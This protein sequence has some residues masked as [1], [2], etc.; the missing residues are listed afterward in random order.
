MA[1]WTESNQTDQI[2]GPFLDL[3][4]GQG[5]VHHQGLGNGLTNADARIQGAI[6]ILKHGLHTLAVHFELFAFQ[7]LN[8]VTL[9]H[10]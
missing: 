5:F 1:R 2:A 7:S 4:F 6:R 3:R 10:D 9:E 8:V